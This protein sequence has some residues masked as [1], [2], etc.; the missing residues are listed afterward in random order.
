MLTIIAIQMQIQLLV[1][2]ITAIRSQ[3]T[4]AEV[5]QI[6]WAPYD[7]ATRVIPVSED[8]PN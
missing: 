1:K 2:Q 3:M 6:N 7:A 4:S 5:A 8:Q